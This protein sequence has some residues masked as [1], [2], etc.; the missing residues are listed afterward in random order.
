MPFCAAAREAAP[1]VMVLRVLYRL[2]DAVR[3]LGC[4]RRDLKHRL[5][6]LAKRDSA[7]LAVR[8][9][10]LRACSCCCARNG[11]YA[12]PVDGGSTEGASNNDE[13]Q[14]WDDQARPNGRDCPL[15]AE[16][17]SSCRS[18]ATFG[19]QIGHNPT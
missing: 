6:G 17:S 8:T 3:R 1:V 2:D 7:C 14:R 18:T 12:T 5:I 19:S 4:G 11:T 9:G 15:G 16:N 13:H 10:G